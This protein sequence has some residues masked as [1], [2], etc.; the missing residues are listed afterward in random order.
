MYALSIAY[1]DFQPGSCRG[2]MREDRTRNPESPVPERAHG[3]IDRMGAME[4]AELASTLPRLLADVV[5]ARGKHDAIVTL[6]E[7]LSY[8]ELDR[9]TARMA[10]AFLAAGAGKRARIALLAPDGVRWMTAFPP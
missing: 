10:R 2:A 6:R 7:T 1:L 5:A 9:R 4:T 3:T 8:D